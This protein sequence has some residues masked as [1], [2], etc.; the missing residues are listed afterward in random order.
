MWSR[1]RIAP[2]RGEKGAGAMTMAAASP[3]I[4]GW[5]RASAQRAGERRRARVAGV[6]LIGG[7]ALWFA[8]ALAFYSRLVSFYSR[9]GDPVERLATVAR[10]HTAWLLQSAIFLIGSLAAVA[11]F[12]ILTGLLSGTR[13]RV[14]ALAGAA[15]ALSYGALSVL[16]AI[17]RF[18]APTSGVRVAADVPAL[19]IAAH[20]GW[21]A[22]LT[23]GLLM[24][25]AILYG[26]ALAHSGRARVAGVIIA[27]FGALLFLS[28]LA[29][30]S[31]RPVTLYPV[32][33]LIGLRL[34]FWPG[35]ADKVEAVNAESA[36]AG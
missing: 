8:G 33:A 15:G 25:T 26:A 9:N 10:E 7:T 30:G 18:A 14:L 4:D 21:L 23:T 11:G 29:G 2:R 6:A 1:A 32:L 16:A 17:Q 35:P 12:V 3:M 28:I 27:V 20:Y 22:V 24:V 5:E 34:L 31:T 13:G 36:V 19:L